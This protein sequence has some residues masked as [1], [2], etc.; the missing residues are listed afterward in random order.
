M[1]P[2]HSSEMRIERRLV[3]IGL[4]SAACSKSGTIDG[5][6]GGER[7]RICNVS[8]YPELM[9]GHGDDAN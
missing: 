3:E 2:R 1:R 9:V 7:V 5:G 4:G 6:P 8:C